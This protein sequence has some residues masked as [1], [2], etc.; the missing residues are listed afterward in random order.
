MKVV[1]TF[2]HPSAVSCSAKC[3]FVPDNRDYLVVGKP[4]RL[5]LYSLQPRGLHLESTLDV[6]GHVVTIRPVVFSVSPIRDV[7][8]KKSHSA[9]TFQSRIGPGRDETAPSDRPPL[10]EI[11]I[12]VVC[13]L[14]R[15]CTDTAG[16]RLEEFTRSRRSTIRGIDRRH[17]Q[18]RRF[19]RGLYLLCP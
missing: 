12:A 9:L 11:G 16:G 10:S 7:F 1:S 19:C 6:W 15:W 14:Q 8:D 18:R 4:N 17:R 5:E 13:A 3:K 2:H